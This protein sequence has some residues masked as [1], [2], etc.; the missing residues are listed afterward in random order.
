MDL[1]IKHYSELSKDLFYEL[2][3]LRIAVFV[4]EQNC[5][6]Q[7]LDGLDQDAY[8]LILKDDLKTMGT[9]RIL[10]PGVAYPE[11]AIG[12]VVIHKVAR[13]KDYG[14]LIMQ[15]AIDFIQNELKGSDI[16][17]SA[18]TY[19]FDF[20]TNLGFKSTGKEY[21]EDGIPHVEMLFKKS[22]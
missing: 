18:Q 17:I 9:L 4:I 6:Y 3:A 5:P 10:K 16:H 11:F 21:L 14:N 8:H 1:S 12:R 15:K 20:Y 19:L 2:A 22:L 7:D 13:R